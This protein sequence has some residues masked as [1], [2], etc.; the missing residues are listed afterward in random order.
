V[1]GVL[2]VMGAKREPAG[3]A[4]SE[5]AVEEKAF[6]ERVT[7]RR[8]ASQAW[9]AEGEFGSRDCGG[10]LVGGVL[11]PDVEPL[12]GVVVVDILVEWKGSGKHEWDSL[13]V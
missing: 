10:G 1:V 5:V 9:K 12:V 4:M 6:G 2:H 13:L 7:S 11:V 8:V 3:S